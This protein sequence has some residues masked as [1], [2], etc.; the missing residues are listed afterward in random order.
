MDMRRAW[1]GA[2]GCLAHQR[3]LGA[4]NNPDTDAAKSLTVAGDGERVSGVR[5]VSQLIRCLAGVG[6]VLTRP[7]LSPPPPPPGTNNLGL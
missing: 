7:L 2:P 1:E 4:E 3:P 6:A 5:A